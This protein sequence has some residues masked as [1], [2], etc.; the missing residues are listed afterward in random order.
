M[1]D[2]EDGKYKFR[3]SPW[4]SRLHEGR[5]REAGD[6]SLD[7]SIAVRRRVAAVGEWVG[8]TGDAVEMEGEGKLLDSVQQSDPI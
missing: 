2:P 5:D 4:R 6:N 8:V 1:E 7:R 3:S